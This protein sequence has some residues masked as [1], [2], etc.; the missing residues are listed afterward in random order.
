MNQNEGFTL[1]ANE[2]QPPIKEIIIEFDSRYSQGKQ[3]LYH[4]CVVLLTIE[5]VEIAI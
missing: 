3:A 5:Q 2:T 1:A 4:T